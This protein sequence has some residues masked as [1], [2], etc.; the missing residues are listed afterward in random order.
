MQKQTR[1][2]RIRVQSGAGSVSYLESR[3]NIV[4][5][6]HADGDSGYNKYM[7]C[8]VKDDLVSQ[9]ISLNN[10]LESAQS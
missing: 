7:N 3:V 5:S 9:L 8:Q 10:K 1:V 6:Q 2:D 4:N